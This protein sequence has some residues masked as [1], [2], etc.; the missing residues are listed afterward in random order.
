M[1]RQEKTQEGLNPPA[2]PKLCYLWNSLIHKE[3]PNHCKWGTVVAGLWAEEVSDEPSWLG[4][5]IQDLISGLSKPALFLYLKAKTNRPVRFLNQSHSGE[6]S[7]VDT[8]REPPMASLL[9]QCYFWRHVLQGECELSQQA[10]DSS[11]HKGD[12]Q[13]LL[14]SS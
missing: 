14:K 4:I 13:T 12:Q 10:W 1:V 7:G 3:S 6:S 5:W 2:L 11:G 9:I 8:R